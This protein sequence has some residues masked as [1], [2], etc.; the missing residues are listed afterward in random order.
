MPVKKKKKKKKK[1]R[2]RERERERAFLLAVFNDIMAVK[3]LMMHNKIMP[4]S[5]RSSP[6]S[7]E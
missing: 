2:E 5:L 6:F 4:V 1:K 7:D 3:G